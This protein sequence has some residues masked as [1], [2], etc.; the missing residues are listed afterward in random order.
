MAKTL[1]TSP[2]GIAVYPRLSTPDTKFNKAGV[3]SVKLRLAA[4]V[5]KKFYNENLKPLLDAS[6]EIAKKNAKT[7]ALAAKITA[8]K[9]YTK[10]TDDDGKETGNILFNFKATAGGTRKADG[11]PWERGPIPVFDA[12]LKPMLD[13]KVG[14]GSE[15]KV[16]FDTAP[17]FIAKE[18]NAGLSLYLEGVQILKLVE[19]TG[20]RNAEG[21]GFGEEDGYDASAA[22]SDDTPAEEDTETSDSMAADAPV[23]E[24]PGSD[25]F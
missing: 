1:L 20:G 4:D 2:K 18:K 10:E 8:V 12:K 9:P 21:M 11:K 25:D 7:P 19:Y 3:Y 24:T 17:Y 16:S 14:G 6:L 15:L 23:E 22:P 5:A 13:A